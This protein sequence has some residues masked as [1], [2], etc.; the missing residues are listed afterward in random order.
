M[1]VEDTHLKKKKK[2]KRDLAQRDAEHD[3]LRAVE[4]EQGANEFPLDDSYTKVWRIIF[5]EWRI[6]YS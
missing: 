5:D 2:K 4:E 6:K 3:R 1:E